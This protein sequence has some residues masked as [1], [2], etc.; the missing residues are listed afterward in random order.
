MKIAIFSDCFL[1][2]K[3]GVVTVIQN[4]IRGLVDLGHEVRLY[5]PVPKR[6]RAKHIFPV[7]YFKVHFGNELRV[8]LFNQRR[9]RQDLI[10]YK[11]D[12]IHSHTEYLQ[13]KLAGKLAKELN[14]PYVHTTHTLWEQYCHYLKIGNIRSPAQVR[15][16]LRRFLS[17]CDVVI[18]PSKK[19]QNYNTRLIQDLNT[20]VVPNGIS[21]KPFTVDQKS[22][23]KNGKTLKLVFAGR[24]APEKKIMELAL[25]FKELVQIGLDVH[26]TVLGD[27]VQSDAVKQC[28]EAEIATQ[29]VV[30]TGNVPYEKIPSFLQQADVFCTFS[31]SEVHPMTVIEAMASGL[32]ILARNDAS[33]LGTVENEKEGYLFFSPEEAKE[34][35]QHLQKNTPLLETM[36][37]AALEKSKR[38]S[39]ES[40]VQMLEEIY[41]GLMLENAIA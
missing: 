24:L 23:K 14:L 1:P 36:K 26:L 28:L 3:N 2:Q 20:I 17:A 41:N 31:Q 27:G 9:V 12:I 7:F 35:I 32:V 4:E 6:Y 8:S 5:A 10:H 15:S 19:I 40:H 37:K 38:F 34:H 25:W 39:R 18:C 16:R 11:A 33:L 13:G 21:L 30:F 22:I 29:K